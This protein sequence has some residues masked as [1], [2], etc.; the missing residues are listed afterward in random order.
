MRHS[1]AARS[2]SFHSAP[3][4]SPGRTKTRGASRSADYQVK[5]TLDPYDLF[6][7]AGAVGAQDAQV[8]TVL[9]AAEGFTVAI[10]GDSMTLAAG[11]QGLGYR[12]DAAGS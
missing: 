3:R 5:V 6:A 4:S 1:A 10:T 11:N 2:I 7:C 8:L 9:G 12:V